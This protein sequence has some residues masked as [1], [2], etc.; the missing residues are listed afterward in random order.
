MEESVTVTTS[1]GGKGKKGGGSTSSSTAFGVLRYDD[2]G[3]L[4]DSFSD[5]FGDANDEHPQEIAVDSLGR[6]LVSGSHKVGTGTY[7]RTIC[8]YS[9]TGTLD[10][11]FGNDGRV[12]VTDDDGDDLAQFYMAVDSLDRVVVAGHSTNPT[13]PS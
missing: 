2:S 8:R 1:G 13:R 12:H 11:T 10:T 4:L 6:I 3:S 7:E 5:D 9:S